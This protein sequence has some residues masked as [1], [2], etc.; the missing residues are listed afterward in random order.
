MWHLNHLLDCASAVSGESG[1]RLFRN[2]GLVTMVSTSESKRYSLAASPVFH[3][4]DEG[5]V[6]KLERPVQR[7]SEQFAAEIIHEV[8]LAMLADVRLDALDIPRPALPPGK[9]ALVSTGRPARSLVRAS[10]T[11]P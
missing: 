6:G 4:L 8:R 9:T 5:F 7:I 1:I 10:P 11:G 3:A 2:C